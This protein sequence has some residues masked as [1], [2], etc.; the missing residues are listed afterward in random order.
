MIEIIKSKGIFFFFKRV[1]FKIKYKILSKIII[2]RDNSSITYFNNLSELSIINPIDINYLIDFDYIDNYDKIEM[3]ADYLCQH[4]FNLLGSGLQEIALNSN[5]LG[6]EG[7]KFDIKIENNYID[8]LRK[9]INSANLDYSLNI[10][11]KL[12]NN[13]RLIDWQRDFRSGYRW[14][15]SAHFHNISFGNIVG[16]DIKHPWELGRLNHLII[17]FYAFKKSKNIKYKYEFINH[18]Y[19][20]ILQNPPNYGVQWL[21]TMDIAIRAVNFITV[22]SLFKNFGEDFTNDFKSYFYNYL[23]S[24]LIY[25]LNNLEWSSGMRAN[26]YFSNICGL[27]FL[28]IFLPINSITSFAFIFALNELK[29]E[30]IYQFYDDGGNFEASLPYH[31][32][33]SEMLFKTISIVKNIPKNHINNIINNFDKKISKQFNF[34]KEIQNRISKIDINKLIQNNV[35]TFDSIFNQKLAKIAEFSINSLSPNF[36]DFQ[37]GDNDSGYFLSLMPIINDD[38]SINS[39]NRFELYNLAK[40]FINSDE[41][42]TSIF[43]KNFGA[44]FHTENNYKIAVRCG[45]IGQNGKGGHA[46]NDQ[47]S[48]ELYS[49]NELLICDAGTYNYTA[50]PDLR[51]LYRSTESHNTLQIP[52][53]E[54]NPIP[55]ESSKLFWL[56]DNAKAEC[57]HYSKRK[58][59]AIHYGFPKAH[60]REF[61]F[62]ENII[63]CR[64]YCEYFGKKMIYF[65]F[66]NNI[67]INK[68]NDKQIFL[69]NGNCKFSIK[70]DIGD[71][72]KKEYFFSPN[73]GVKYSSHLIVITFE[74]NEIN[75]EI[76]ILK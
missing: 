42:Q 25:I 61:N 65:H 7:C 23:Y 31:S 24:H 1:F 58:F 4:K 5:Y 30:T 29:N 19:D 41:K 8:F 63:Y 60:T 74:K 75:W 47:L 22:Y 52:N 40:K 49:R 44:F 68:M 76:E 28:S 62:D 43:M 20:F 11:K 66:P 38:F 32:F 70:F 72:T 51:N 15:T 10:L 48:F 12:D 2:M 6:F 53:F 50:F 45:N 27:I 55:K 37:I 13:Y 71:A 54:Q 36:N 21:S 9:S 64:D 39:K 14:E 18:I 16:V 33:V 56:I 17:L 59:S 69:S 26:H 35:I 73:Y 57:T 3:F 46:H 34:P 67:Q